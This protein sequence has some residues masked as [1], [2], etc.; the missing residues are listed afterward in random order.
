MILSIVPFIAML[1]LGKFNGWLYMC[2]IVNFL[3]STAD[4]IISFVVIRLVPSNAL[5]VQPSL[6]YVDYLLKP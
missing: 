1:I 4:I 2:T 6:N 3:I 5:D